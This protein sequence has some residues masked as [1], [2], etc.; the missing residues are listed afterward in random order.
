MLKIGQQAHIRI[1][2]RRAAASLQVLDCLE[3]VPTADDVQP[4]LHVT[5]VFE[6]RLGARARC[7]EECVEIKLVKLPSARDRHQLVRHLIG[8]QAHLW[9]RTIRIPLAGALGG[10]IFL[11]A[12]LVGVGPVEYLLLDELARSERPERGAGEVEIRFGRD[13]QELGLLLREHAEVL[14]ETFVGSVS[15]IRERYCQPSKCT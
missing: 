3:R 8:E 2:K 1:R 10:E 15:E 9:Q 5:L 12:L 11:G 13:G 6:L 4:L 7:L 14:A